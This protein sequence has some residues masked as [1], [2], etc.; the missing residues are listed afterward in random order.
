MNVNTDYLKYYTAFFFV[1]S[2]L[3][4]LKLLRMLNCIVFFCIKQQK[5]VI[6][7]NHFFES[8]RKKNREKISS[9]QKLEEIQLEFLKQI[10]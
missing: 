7:I 5:I 1:T 4:S 3:I 9:L 6:I 10:I 8:K 2:T